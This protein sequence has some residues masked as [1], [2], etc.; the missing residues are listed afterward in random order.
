MSYKQALDAGIITEAGTP[1]GEIPTL[2]EILINSENQTTEPLFVNSVLTTNTLKNNFFYNESVNGFLY[3]DANKFLTNASPSNYL[4]YTNQGGQ[5]VNNTGQTV[6]NFV[7]S[8]APANTVGLSYSNGQFTNTNATR[9]LTC[10]ISYSVTFKG[11]SISGIPANNGSRNV[12]IFS[13][14]SGT[15]AGNKTTVGTNSDVII[16]GT[17]IFNVN[18]GNLNYISLYCSQSSFGPLV[19]YPTIQILAF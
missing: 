10:I 11:I 15:T 13:F 6:L 3:T 4:Y 9:K 12:S 16:S 2:N 7:D 1:V 18:Q 8:L 19:V 5:S 14:S 17:A